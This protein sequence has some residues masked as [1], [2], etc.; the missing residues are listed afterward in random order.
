MFV[1]AVFNKLQRNFDNYRINLVIKSSLFVTFVH[2]LKW[3][4]KNSPVC[5]GNILFGLK[6]S[7][8]N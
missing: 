3:R 6:H 5:L 4:K 8:S 1:N 7:S 2:I